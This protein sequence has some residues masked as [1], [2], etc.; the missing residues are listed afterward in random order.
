M[1]R[2]RLTHGLAHGLAVLCFAVLAP[3]AEAQLVLRPAVGPSSSIAPTRFRF[4]MGPNGSAVASNARPVHA[5][6]LYTTSSRYGWVNPAAVALEFDDGA[7]HEKHV[8]LGQVSEEAL[9]QDGV[10][11]QQDY[12]FRARLISDTY[13][14]VVTLGRI[15][16][17]INLNPPLEDLE[18]SANGAKVILGDFTRLARSKATFDDAWG[19]YKRRSFLIKSDAAGILDVTFHGQAGV[20]VPVLGIEFQRYEVEPVRFQDATSSLVAG[21]GYGPVLQGALDLINSGDYSGARAALDAITSDDL[22]QAW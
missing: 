6:T 22:A 15:G 7:I 4:D 9:L 14:C 3:L 11:S 13:R 21:P 8:F 20:P 1:V 16:D 2:P 12:T 17:D 18:V 19:G 10:S 5:S